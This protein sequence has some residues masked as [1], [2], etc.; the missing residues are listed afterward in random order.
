M[1]MTG[2]GRVIPEGTVTFLFS[3]IEESTRLVETLETSTY[4]RVLEHHNR[5]LRQ[6]FS[7]H[8][9][10]VRGTEGDS[11]LVVFEEAPAGVQ[12]AVAAQRALTHTDWP[13]G[14]EVRVR[15]GLHTG[16]GIRGADDYVGIDINRA[17]RIS[18]AAH[19]GQILISDATRAL[20][21]RTLPDDIN[22]R[23]LGEH[24]LKGLNKPERLFQ[25]V[26]NGIGDEFPPPRAADGGPAHLPARLTSFIGREPEMKSIRQLLD[27]NRLVTL[28]GPGGTGKT[29]LAIEAAREFADSFRDG[30]WFVDLAPVKEYELVTSTIAAA[31]GLVTK[32]SRPVIEILQEHLASRQTLLILDN[33]EHLLP[34][35]E[36]VTQLTST[37]SRLSVLVTSRIGL[38]VYGE[39]ILPVPSLGLPA[40]DDDI[41]DFGDREAV[42]LF[43]ERARSALPDFTLTETNAESV[44][45]ICRHLD[46]LPLAIELA[47]NRVRVLTVEEIARRLDDRLP[48]LSG[49][50]MN[51]P[52][53]HQ[54]LDA[55][56]E[57]S[58]DLLPPV[59][60]DFFARL[61]V[62]VGGFTLDA[63]ERVCNPEG[64]LGIETLDGI[65]SLVNQ[66]LL[67]RLSVAGASR[68]DMLETIREFARERL[69]A[70]PAEDEMARRHIH[71]FRDLAEAAEPHLM[72]PDQNEWVGA[73]E[74]E[75]GNL[76]Q[77][78]R[79]ALD[80]GD[81]DESG[82]SIASSIWRF[83]FERGYLHEG[84]SW[85]E[86]L[87]SV[88]EG[89][90]SSARAKAHSALGGLTYWLS[91]AEATE[92][93]YR[94]ALDI[95]VRIG[96]DEATA[97][98]LYNHA[99]A[100]SMKGDL[101]ETRKRMEASLA[102]AEE[103]GSPHLIARNQMG[104]AL[105]ALMSDEA[106]R[107]V[108]IL[109]KAEQIF[110]DT[111]DSFHIMWVCGNLGFAYIRLGDI[112]RGRAALLE[113]IE[114]S[115]KLMNPAIMVAALRT[116]AALES[117]MHHHLEAV[118]LAGASEALQQET[119][120]DS[121][122]PKVVNADL[123]LARSVLGTA[124]F[125]RALD[126][127]RRMS[128]A[129]AV[130]YANKALGEL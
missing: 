59:E 80:S 78:L 13:G 88:N 89:N 17:A 95:W 61:S 65:M 66:S 3:D 60:Q 45:E 107:A 44:F 50:E 53:R 26:V 18:S 37:A 23:D 2:R 106:E 123:D 114:L 38:S 43:V 127:G 64:E 113:S 129:D 110:R 28:T 40:I 99:F 75:H 96:D 6:V 21:E 34:A 77:A 128:M 93:A 115:T 84:R 56:V 20:T 32:T 98:A 63:A 104:I 15:M 5:L 39:Q 130:E 116:L 92:T 67:R 19:G 90:P 29:S 49:S 120:A 55:L 73:L 41:R 4:R 25:L 16:Q 121:P 35:A 86:S 91:D 24:R 11:F 71:Y 8:E 122:L 27:E 94:H 52:P 69:R 103:L 101:E 76:R 85:L 42:A 72:S 108:G 7:E 119:G 105:D 79:N 100:S 51:R 74:T 109:E 54:T 70:T 124:V 97:E 22:T 81:G 58:Y 30:A 68:Y 111:D 10:V 102:A 126:E 36:V 82:L 33:F 47:A 14:A 9:G 125:E 1:E 48:V 87:L 12:A 62:F 46:G 118:R 83:W 31:L 117:T 57:W 112:E